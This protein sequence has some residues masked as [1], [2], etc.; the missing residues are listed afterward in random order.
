[1]G[2]NAFIQEMFVCLVYMNDPRPL[3]N[4][5]QWTRNGC[6]FC[7]KVTKPTRHSEGSRV[8]PERP[9]QTRAARASETGGSLL[10]TWESSSAG[11]L[12]SWSDGVALLD[13]PAVLLEPPSTPT[14][15]RRRM[16]ERRC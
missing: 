5:A 1:M 13:A 7:R 8:A 16:L 15:R 4:P 11:R 10:S 2:D 12:H 3:A 9:R 6:Q 14:L